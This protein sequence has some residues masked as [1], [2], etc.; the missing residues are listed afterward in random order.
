MDY[1]DKFVEE[2][3]DEYF[4]RIAKISEGDN[5]SKIGDLFGPPQRKETESFDEYTT[6]RKI[7]QMILR[8][9]KRGVRFVEFSNN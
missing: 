4:K 1:L 2:L 7:E 6:R 5:E 8:H 9:Y 3:T